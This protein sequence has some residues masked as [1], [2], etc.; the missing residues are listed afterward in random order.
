MSAA[1]VH[2]TLAPIRG[3][4]DAVY[5]QAFA[6]VFGGFERAVAPFVQLRQGQSLRAADLR[7]L[8]PENNRE[9]PTIPQVLTNHADTFKDALRELCDQGHAEVNWNLG[10]P[11]PMVTKRGRG[12][13]LL[14]TPER[15]AA[16]LDSVLNECPVRLSAK[17]RLGLRDPD[18]SLAV[19]EVLSRYPLSEVILH[20]RTA[21]QMYEG[22][23]DVERAGCALAL[24]RHPFVYNGD[25]TTPQG[26][27]ELRNRLPAA[28]GWMIGR[29]ALTHQFFPALIQGTRLPDPAARRERLREFHDQLLA[30]YR[31]WLSGP[32]HL[33]AKMNEQWQYLASSFASPRPVLREIRHCRD[34]A[35]YAAAVAWVFDQ[36]LAPAATPGTD[37]GRAGESLRISPESATRS[38]RRW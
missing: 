7:Q 37:G 15:I 1:Q 5:R 24:W 19:L 28:S 13:G 9:L 6:R 21:E 34:L 8:A 4:T 38:S 18:E 26:F 29:G 2:L 17:L 12:A 36:P 27:C 20:P 23:V 35:A 33:L 14:P 10:C 32:A 25:I 30:G 31:S 11:Y 16:I 22:P 3:I